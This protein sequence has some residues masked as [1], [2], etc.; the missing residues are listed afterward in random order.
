MLWRR[1]MHRDVRCPIGYCP[2]WSLH[3]ILKRQSLAQSLWR[4]GIHG[5]LAGRFFSPFSCDDQIGVTLEMESLTLTINCS[6]F[7]CLPIAIVFTCFLLPCVPPCFFREYSRASCSLMFN[8]RQTGL[9]WQLQIMVQGDTWFFLKLIIEEL[10][11]H[12]IDVLLFINSS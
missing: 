1:K 11:E 8:R 12:C 7:G 10:G 9:Q 4:E 6:F 2:L 3:F 5:Y